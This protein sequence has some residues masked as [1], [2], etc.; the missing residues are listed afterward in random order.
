MIF[1]NVLILYDYTTV[2]TAPTVQNNPH[3]ND[4]LRNA[5][6]DAYYP[7]DDDSPFEPMT[8]E[9]DRGGIFLKLKP[10]KLGWVHNKHLV[11]DALYNKPALL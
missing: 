6:E 9:G 11:L 3:G 5:M 2:G 10:N 4:Y 1:G 8:C 7:D